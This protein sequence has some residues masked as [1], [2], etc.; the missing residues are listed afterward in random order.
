MQCVIVNISIF[1]EVIYLLANEIDKDDCL[2][3]VR[4]CTQYVSQGNGKLDSNTINDETRQP[5]HNGS[6]QTYRSQFPTT[7]LSL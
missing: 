5:L 3:S 2:Q 7:N 4:G 1:S 6:N